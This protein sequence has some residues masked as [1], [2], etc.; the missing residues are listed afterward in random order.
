MKFDI[1][2]QINNKIP[3]RSKICLISGM[4]IGWLTHF[5]MLSHK[6]V[7][8]DDMNSL[9]EFGS[10]DY[11]GRWFLKFIHPLGS[12]ADQKYNW[13]NFS[14][15][16]DGYISKCCEYDDLYVYGTYVWNCYF[17][18][19]S[20]SVSFAEIQVRVVALWCAFDLCTWHIPKLY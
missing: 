20:C 17:H 8:W 12:N 15:C 3:K 9:D 2:A 18:G 11:L 19:V 16:F 4:I 5:Y 7:N 10:G 14:A 1:L 13:S 6:L